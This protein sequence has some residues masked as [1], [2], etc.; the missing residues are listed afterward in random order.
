MSIGRTPFCPKSNSSTQFKLVPENIIIGQKGVCPLDLY[1]VFHFVRLYKKLTFFVPWEINK[2]GTFYVIRTGG[3][4]RKQTQ[5]TPFP[6]GI[7]IFEKFQKVSKI[8][9]KIVALS[10][11]FFWPL[12]D[13]KF[14][15]FQRLVIILLLFRLVIYHPPVP[16]SLYETR[17]I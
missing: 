17:S 6:Q 14:Q 12:S 15:K 9:Y 11:V 4:I 16:M 10:E 1:S 13:F 2:I 7:T 8:S 5:K 3:T